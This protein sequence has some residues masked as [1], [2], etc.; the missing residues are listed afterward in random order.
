MDGLRLHAEKNC[1]KILTPAAPCGP[2]VQYW[3]NRI[4]ALKLMKRMLLK[5]QGKYN[6][7]NNFRFASHLMENPKSYNLMQIRDG[8]RYCKIKQKEARN[9]AI[10]TR[11]QMLR[12]RL[13]VAV[14]QQDKSKISG[15]KQILNTEN[16]KKNWGIVNATLDDPRSPPLTSI[17]REEGDSLVRYDTEEGVERVFKEECVSRYNLAKKAPVMNSSLA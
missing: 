11:D 17:L 14:R 12:D 2:E 8:I 9:R 15:I 16:S 7:S 4:H 10:P 6:S 5:P 13:A 1:R 3:Y